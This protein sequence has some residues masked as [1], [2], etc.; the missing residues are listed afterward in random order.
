MDLAKLFYVDGMVVVTLLVPTLLVG[1][2]FR[3]MT[4]PSARRNAVA[5]ADHGSLQAAE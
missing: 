5:R 1:F 4:A 2:W 3:D